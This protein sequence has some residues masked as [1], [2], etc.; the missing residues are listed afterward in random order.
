VKIFFI[1]ASFGAR[2]RRAVW[3]RFEPPT[4]ENTAS[5]SHSSL[6]S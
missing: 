6:A 1:L 4:W 5:H 2:F 3:F